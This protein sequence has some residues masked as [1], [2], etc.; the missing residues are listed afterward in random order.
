LTYTRAVLS[1][2]LRLF[3]P[4]FVITRRAVA[5]DRAGDVDIPRGS[6][7]MVSPFVL[8]R[9]A[10][11]WTDPEIFDPS[12]FLGDATPA[13]PFAFL[14]FGAGPRVCVGA[15]F[16]LTEAALVLA[17]LIKR[18][19]ITRADDVPV[20]PVAAITTQPDHPAAF[21]FSLRRQAIEQS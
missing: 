2:A 14:P 1:E 10:R 18:F 17:M 11:L 8:H 4:A 12:R 3:P 7:V 19:E 15:H 20:L 16:A 9:H 21:L 5:A 13:H 6:M